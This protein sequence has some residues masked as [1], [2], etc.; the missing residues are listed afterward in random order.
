MAQQW[1]LTEPAPQPT[2]AGKGAIVSGLVVL[3][4]GVVLVIAGIVGSISTVANL[5]AGLGPPRTTPTE[6]TQTFDAGTTYAVYEQA[7]SGSG[8]TG[9][10][11]LGSVTP[12]DITV[13]APDGSSVP[14]TEAPSFSQT[15]TNSSRTFVVVATFDPPVS[16]AY[17]VSV[18]T[19]GATVV[20]APSITVLGRSLPWLALAGVGFVLG[21]AGIVVLVV[22]VVRRSSSRRPPAALPGYAGAGYPPPGGPAPVPTPA[23]V[24]P[25]AGWY[26]D[27]ERPGVRRY[28]DGTTWTEHRA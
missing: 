12:G 25:P 27:P 4:V 16:G 6:F 8:T 17:D 15:Y 2:P 23:P 3:L 9:D 11:Y 20:V 24:L 14:V 21:L 19:E 5:F 10:P 7:T 13:T 26:P 18:S 28:W 22:G 1:S